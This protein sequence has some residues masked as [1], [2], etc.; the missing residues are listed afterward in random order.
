MFLPLKGAPERRLPLREGVDLNVV[1]L[2]IHFSGNSLPLREGV[3][4]N[5]SLLSSLPVQ[6][7]LPLREGVDLNLNN[8]RVA[9]PF[10][11]SPSA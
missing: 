3:D 1:C 11:A 2:K 8:R 4:L 6:L 5:E 9:F 7:R 10:Q